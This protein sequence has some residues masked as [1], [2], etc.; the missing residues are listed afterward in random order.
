MQLKLTNQE[1]LNLLKEE[2]V[3]KA[4]LYEQYESQVI[5]QNFLITNLE[6]FVLS[7]LSYLRSLYNKEKIEDRKKVLN[8]L[9]SVVRYVQV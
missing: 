6:V 9:D 2:R 4:Q 1:L 8:E 7:Q 5:F 3:C